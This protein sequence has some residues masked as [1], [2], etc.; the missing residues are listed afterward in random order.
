MVVRATDRVPGTSAAARHW[1]IGC[2]NI[3][4]CLAATMRAHIAMREL[5]RGFWFAALRIG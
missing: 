5:I 1:L 2:M 4:A 3:R